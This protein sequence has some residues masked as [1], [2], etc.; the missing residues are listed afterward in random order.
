MGRNVD[1][2]KSVTRVKQLKELA[3]LLDT[4][5]SPL[6]VAISGKVA[7]DSTIIC[8]LSGLASVIVED[9]VEQ[10]FLKHEKWDW[11]DHSPV[12]SFASKEVS[13][14]LEDATGCVD[15]VGAQQAIDFMLPFQKEIF[16]QSKPWM[17]HRIFNYFRGLK[18]L[19]FKRIER[20]LP[21]NTS[22][23]VIGEVS[24]DD[25]GTIRIQ[26]PQ[27]GPFYVSPNTIDDLIIANHGDF[28]RW[29]KYASIG[30]SIFGSCIIAMH[31]I[32]YILTWRRQCEMH[33]RVLKAAAIIKMSEQQPAIRVQS[34][35]IEG[36]MDDDFSDLC[37]ICIAQKYNVAFV[38]CGHMC[39]CTT[40]SRPLK[41]CP[42]CRGQIKQVIRI[43]YP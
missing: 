19:G 12:T 34:A 38:P 30:F 23:T 14:Y 26:K 5:N 39:C 28:V 35:N 43:F 2:L 22:L 24:K 37:V 4:R 32:Q 17:I 33:K 6:L 41:M 3:Q 10:H 15:V 18:E 29:C 9:T 20:T 11:K 21:I 16:K 40:C 13:W 36:K 31:T 42:L 25:A 7:A 27:S 8:E 1:I